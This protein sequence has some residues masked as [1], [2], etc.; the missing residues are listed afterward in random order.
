[1]SESSQSK[2][3]AAAEALVEWVKDRE[4]AGDTQNYIRAG[5]LNKSVVASEL[6]FA[7]SAWQTNP[8]LAE[9]ADRLD[10]KWGT[11]K[12]GHNTEASQLMRAY[13]DRHDTQNNVLPNRSGALMLMQIIDEAG[14]SLNDFAQDSAVRE[15]LSEYADVNGL[16]VSLPGYVAPAEEAYGRTSQ[17][18]SEMVPVKKLR[19]A[20][21]RVSQLEKK[22]AEL[23]TSNAALR[24]DMLR[25]KSIEDLIAKGGR[26]SPA[27]I[28]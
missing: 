19:D 16:S 23:R 14:V 22:I 3:I 20:Q 18:P 11:S 1:M 6:G 9:M 5:K 2:A 7:R 21:T 25:S 15:L 26:I 12:K 17:D 27:E 24:A 10:Q 13:I 4:A 28:K 8:R